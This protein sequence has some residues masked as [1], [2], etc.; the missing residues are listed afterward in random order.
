M[1]QSK[2]RSHFDTRV[3]DVDMEKTLTVRAK[4][5]LDGASTIDEVIAK[6]EAEI[7]HYKRMKADRWELEGKIDDDWGFLVQVAP[8]EEMV[9]SKFTKTSEH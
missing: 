8:D 2:K 9:D 4:W 1:S 5:I 3:E 6:L 7:E